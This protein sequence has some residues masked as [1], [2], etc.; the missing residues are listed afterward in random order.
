MLQF[1]GKAWEEVRSGGNRK[2]PGVTAHRQ[3][4]QGKMGPLFYCAKGSL[5]GHPWAAHPWM[6]AKIG[7]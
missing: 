4:K 6:A 2:S 1:K 7:G 3:R 5:E